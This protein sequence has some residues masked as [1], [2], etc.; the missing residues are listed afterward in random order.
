MPPLEA[1]LDPASRSVVARMRV[2]SIAIWMLWTFAGTALGAIYVIGVFSAQHEEP[3]STWYKFAL[4]LVV[5]CSGVVGC[6]VGY[7]HKIG[8]DWARQILVVMGQI[9]NR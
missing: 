7:L 1:S 6:L 5:L 3:L 8:I 9:A 4:I 2:I